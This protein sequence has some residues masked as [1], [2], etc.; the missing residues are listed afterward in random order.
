METLVPRKVDVL[1]VRVSEPQMN[2]STNASIVFAFP[3]ELEVASRDLLF[4]VHLK[5]KDE[6]ESEWKSLRYTEYEN[7]EKSGEKILPLRDLQF[8][9]T[10]YQ[11]KLRIKSKSSQESEEMWSPF[12]NT[13]TFKTKAKVPEMIA[14]VCE[15][16]FNIMDNGNI[17][18]YWREILKFHQNG[19]N[20][21]YFIRIIDQDDKILREVFQRKSFL[22]IPNDV[23]ATALTIH[24]YS[25]N[26]E[27]LSKQYSTVYV[28]KE[29]SK[30]KLSIRKEL[31]SDVGYKLSWQHG[32]HVKGT[33]SYTILWCRQRNELPNQCDSSIDYLESTLESTFLFNTSDS[34]QFGIAVNRKVGKPAG[35]KWAKCT[36]SKPD[37]TCLL[38]L[39]NN[40][41]I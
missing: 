38:K 5:A 4:D 25:S 16:C 28:P 37:G 32:D 10:I 11:F 26:A 8:A 6:N 12:T 24:I 3:R 35:F 27:G 13:T 31:V 9:N 41:F 20:F 33:V 15:N 40:I 34:Y 17:F 30:S 22:M 1:S 23:N 39:M 29:E 7:V 36:S 2:T 14:N 21:S 19:D 18:V